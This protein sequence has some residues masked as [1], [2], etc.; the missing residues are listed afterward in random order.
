MVVWCAAKTSVPFENRPSR[1]PLFGLPAPAQASAPKR[2]SA[3]PSDVGN[4]ARD[5][6]QTCLANAEKLRGRSE[7]EQYASGMTLRVLLVEDSP[8]DA[9]LLRAQLDTLD[10]DFN[11]EWVPTFEE[12]YARAATAD[13]ALVDLTLPDVRGL[14]SIVGLAEA[15]PELPVIVLTGIGDEAGGIEAVR[16][17]AQ[18]YLLKDDITAGDLSR[19]IRYAVE[20]KG[21]AAE[22]VA[23]AS[24][25]SERTRLLALSNNTIFDE[26]PTGMV[27]LGAD[28]RILIANKAMAALAGSTQDELVGRSV[29]DLLGPRHGNGIVSAV[30]DVLVS[31][32]PHRRD[33]LLSRADGST[34]LTTLQLSRL[35]MDASGSFVVLMT[36]DDI[37][38]G[39]S[40]MLRQA[41]DQKLD[42]LSRLASGLAHEIR[43]PLQYVTT[44]LDFARSTI[45][46]LL[47]ADQGDTRRAELD[48]A[49]GEVSEG[50]GRI[51]EIVKGMTI[52]SQRSGTEREVQ[53]LNDV[54][55]FPLAVARGQAPAG[56]VFDVTTG[57]VPLVAFSLGLLQQVVLNLL[58]NG[59]HAIED[60]AA[61]Q[62]RFAGRLDVETGHDDQS[63]WIRVTD[64]GLGMDSAL[65]QQAMEPFFTTKVEG[66]GTGQGLALVQEIMDQHGG[67]LELES[68]EAKGTTATVLL[69][70]KGENAR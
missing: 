43:S 12:G 14:E 35:T 34:R 36:V 24:E 8:S 51:G 15:A 62:A 67:R 19:A 23:L 37:T 22:L 49:L 57:D 20:R 2:T 56:T 9:A 44:S 68:S 30:T 27:Q 40:A 11:V 26:S 47:G 32:E 66:R 48:E 29:I 5:D 41:H 13:C 45:G 28:A 64:N 39:S 59:V 50:I 53:D 52:L 4:L 42:E 16:L 3:T 33:A 65:V 70:R 60:R 61:D 10:V 54:L 1:S 17:G 6:R 21:A 58:V 55:P 63:A 46:D 38:A 25:L 69:P 31:G 18:D 7:T